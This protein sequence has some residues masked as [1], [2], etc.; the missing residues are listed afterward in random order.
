VTREQSIAYSQEG[1]SV[2]SDPEEHRPGYLPDVL[3]DATVI[4][5][6][7]VPDPELDPDSEV[8]DLHSDLGRKYTAMASGQS[9]ASRDTGVS[10]RSADPIEH[11]RF[12][13]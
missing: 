6:D 2:R 12:E 9:I 5:L 11:C 10:L 3:H 13:L 7:V 8:D 1:R 4:R